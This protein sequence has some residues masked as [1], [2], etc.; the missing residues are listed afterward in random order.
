MRLLE[1]FN[2]VGNLFYV[3]ELHS[4]KPEV[5]QRELVKEREKL[6]KAF[7]FALLLEF[8]WKMRWF[9]LRCNPLV[10][11]TMTKLS[12][13]FFCTRYFVFPLFGATYSNCSPLWVPTPFTCLGFGS[14]YTVDLLVGTHWAL[15]NYPNRLSKFFVEK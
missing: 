3:L 9:Y 10:I 6:T 7:I 2:L 14:Y 15:A 12:L 4:S 11:R 5:D 8:R 13:F 1:S